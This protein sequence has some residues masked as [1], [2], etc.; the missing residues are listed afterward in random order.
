MVKLFKK[1]REQILEK[2]NEA[3]IIQVSEKANFFGLE[4]KG[5]KQVRG[6]GVLVLTKNELF[7]QMWL[8]KRIIK[9]PMGSIKD[10]STPTHHLR[11]TKHIKLLKVEFINQNG[12]M[13]S[14][15]WWV[16]DLKE[17]TAKITALLK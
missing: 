10:I 16:K 14:S 6:N 5:S 3:D 9:I 12:N 4:S 15:T 8:P 11:K 13:D 1:K 7:F 17:W 2:F